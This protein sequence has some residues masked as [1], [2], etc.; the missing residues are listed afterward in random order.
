MPSVNINEIDVTTLGK[1]IDEF[2]EVLTDKERLILYALIR[3]AT[4][5][6]QSLSASQPKPPTPSTGMGGPRLGD[7][8]DA[9]FIPGK[10]AVFES[11]TEFSIGPVEISG[12]LGIKA[13]IK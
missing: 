12:E 5:H 13:G 10:A 8:F 7:A 4:K 11:Q 6:F 2:G 1:K 9:A 3:A